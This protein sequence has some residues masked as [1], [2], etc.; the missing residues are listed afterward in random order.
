[1]RGQLAEALRAGAIGLSTSRSQH[2]ETSDGRPV[3]SRQ[4]AW[5]E[6]VDLVDVM[7]EAGAGILEIADDGMAAAEPTQRAG[8][9]E[10]ISSLGA[11]SR[12]PI[13]FGLVATRAAAPLLDFLD[14]SATVGGR[15]IAQTHCRGHLGAAV[16]RDPAPVRPARRVGSA[17]SAA[18][19][20]AARDPARPRAWCDLR[21]RGRPGRLRR[22]VG[23][24]GAG[25]AP[26]LRGHQGLPARAAT[27][28][29]RRRSGPRARR[30]P[31]RGDDP[32]LRGV[33]RPTSCSSNRAATH[34]TRRPS[35]GRC[36]TPGRS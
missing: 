30:P 18:P 13:T 24:G 16:A 28:P 11:R 10:R 21:R 25:A 8:A 12:V 31:R 1:M 26:G 7:S 19:R 5:E 36:D 27:Q 15:I 32:A 17:A 34:R 22:V 2:H 9:F 4:A 3:A 14:E 23:S 6:V 20:R 29:L 35:C 33:R